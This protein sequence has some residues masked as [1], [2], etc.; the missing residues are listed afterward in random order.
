M[1][2][3]NLGGPGFA[4]EV[5]SVDARRRQ[6]TAMVLSLLMAGASAVLAL[7]AMLLPDASVRWPLVILSLVIAG[8]CLGAAALARFG[9]GTAAALS[10]IGLAIV[11]AWV[12]VLGLHRVGAAPA[13]TCS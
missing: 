10:L 3:M 4:R 11:A 8:L 13:G 9:Y 12:T 7:G 1:R 6:R 5:W 2:R